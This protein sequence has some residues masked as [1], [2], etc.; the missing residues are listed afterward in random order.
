ML[1]CSL[2][3]VS[4][5][6]FLWL[7][8]FQITSQYLDWLRLITP[9]V[10]VH[11]EL[12]SILITSST[13]A[14]VFLGKACLNASALKLCFFFCAAVIALIKTEPVKHVQDLGEKVKKINLNQV[15][16]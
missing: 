5:G 16:K 15:T 11:S 7:S 3:A 14:R 8:S 9:Y 12:Y 10:F 4:I 1:T 13:H 6:V 2:H